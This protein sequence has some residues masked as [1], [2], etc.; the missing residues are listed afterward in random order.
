MNADR[1][2]TG[3]TGWLSAPRPGR[4]VRI[5]TGAQGW[6]LR[7]YPELARSARRVAAALIADG[8]LAGDVV[9]VLMPTGFDVLAAFFG[10]WA[11]GA[12][13]CLISPPSFTAE[14]DYAV[15]VAAVLAQAAP[16][17]CVTAPELMPVTARAMAR[18]GLAG[19]PWPLREAGTEAGPVPPGD[20]ALLQFT[21]GSSGAPRGARV[22][23]ASLA[24]NIALIKGWLDWSDGDVTASWLPLYHDMGLIGCLLI[25]VTAQCDLWLMRPAQFVREPLR[26]LECMTFAQHTAAPPFALEYIARRVRPEQ[27]AELDLSGWRNIIVGAELIEPAVLEDFARLPGPAGFRRAGYVTAYGLAEATLAVTAH[28]GA[29]P[30]RAVRLDAATLHAGMPVGIEEVYR[31]SGEAPS[32]GRTGW[33]VGCGRP[34]DGVTVRIVA[35]DG[36]VLPPGH[37]GEIAVTGPSVA[38]GYHAGRTG[39]STRFEGFELLTG[40]AGFEY[41]GELFVLGRVGD[42]LKVRG[43]SVYVEDLEAVVAQETGLSRAR[44]AV[45]SAPTADGAR[46]A[47][48]A[49]SA[50][51]AWAA[52]ARDA[53]AARLGQDVAI[54]VISG[55]S[56]LVARTTSGKPRRALLGSLLAGGL[57]EGACVLAPESD[58]GRVLLPESGGVR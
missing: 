6:E 32:A 43:R 26:W 10:V 23:W 31:L 45:V 33:V 47:L 30:P 35:E 28:C 44:F 15:R 9:C 25:P 7:E 17:L 34:R 55:R 21:S 11:A 36:S 41:D 13:P 8:V 16:R 51:G 48:L 42:S 24:A 19:A 39:G 38:D 54:T 20:L 37:L 46:V 40:D 52:A 2:P 53:L 1:G 49:E 29:Q 18:A 58:G 57:P 50:P 14:D 4:G 12:T 27:L 3:L 5:A 22:T 56:G